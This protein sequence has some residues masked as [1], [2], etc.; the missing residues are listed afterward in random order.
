MSPELD[1]TPMIDMTFLLL[2]FFLVASTPDRQAEARLPRARHGVAV[3]GQD[4]IVLTVGHSGESTA[5][6]YLGD[7]KFE[8]HRLPSDLDL[9]QERIAHYVREE[10]AKRK[11]GAAHVLIK[12]D[13]E[14]AHREV[15]RVAEAVSGIEGIELHFAVRDMD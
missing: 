7:G 4:A 2:I 1:I 11:G 8:V 13:R 14:V 10:V 9:Q 15:A 5:P 6:V 3:S 12:A